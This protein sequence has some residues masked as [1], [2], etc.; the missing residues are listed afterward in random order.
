[1]IGT[2]LVRRLA[3]EAEC[4]VLTLP[5]AR[6]EVTHVEELFDR[7]RPQEVYLFAAESHGIAANQKHPADIMTANLLYEAPLI[8]AAHRTGVK[9]LLYLASS[10]CYPRDCPQPMQPASLLSGRLEPTNE[11]YAVAKLASLTMCRAY[12]GQHGAD[13]IVG[14]PATPFG[15]GDDFSVENSHVA[16][17]LLRRMHEAREAGAE[18]VAI[19][20]SGSPRRDFI[21]ADDLADACV[22][23]MRQ[24][25]GDDPLHLA[26]GPDVS[27]RE[28]AEMIRDVVG[29]A[30]EIRFDTSKP[31]GALLKLLDVAP[32][33]ALGW[34]PATPLR[35]G[36]QHAYD[37]FLDHIKEK[38]HA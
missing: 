37:W 28:L 17:A 33:R 24:Y 4:E 23:A 21:F 38:S 22:F 19:W 26:G 1:M 10:C 12:R 35:A 36:L 31:D 8:A 15:P 7:A 30:G 2:A 27:I 13:F 5:R 29:F 6:D 32:L 11:A 3:R 9:K 18:H 34:E 14:I 20:G 16:S 25:S